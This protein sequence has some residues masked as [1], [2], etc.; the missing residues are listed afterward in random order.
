MY[1]NIWLYFDLLVKIDSNIFYSNFL[2]TWISTNG[3]Y[4]LQDIQ[5]FSSIS[6]QTYNKVRLLSF[7]YKYIS[8]SLALKILLKLWIQFIANIKDMSPFRVQS[9]FIVTSSSKSNVTMSWWVKY[10]FF[11]FMYTKCISNMCHWFHKVG[12]NQTWNKYDLNA[13]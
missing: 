8:S 10:I 9:N 13:G 11:K 3:K 12:I 1:E 6:W 5:V 4:H 2:C 7:I